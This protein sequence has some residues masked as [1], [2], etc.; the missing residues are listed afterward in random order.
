MNKK[1]AIKILNLENNFTKEQ[2]KKQYRIKALELHPDKNKNEDANE[3]FQELGEA[4]K[5]L[6]NNISCGLPSDN[7][8]FDNIDLNDNYNN[9]VKNFILTLIDSPFSLN[10]ITNL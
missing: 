6:T 1:K 5:Y 8:F 3:R 10:L 2:L 4:Y 7:D 9:I